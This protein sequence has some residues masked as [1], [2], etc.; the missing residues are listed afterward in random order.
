MKLKM[1]LNLTAFAFFVLVTTFPSQADPQKMYG[2]QGD[3]LS[4]ATTVPAPNTYSVKGKIY[5]TKD[6]DEAKNYSKEG[7]ASYYHLKFNGNKTASGD[8]YNSSLFTAAHKTLP[9]NSYALVTNLHNN[10]KVI[11]RINDRG[12]FSDKRLIDLSHAAA[13]ELGL[14]A[15]GTGQV[16][17][18]ALHVAKNGQLSGAATKTLAMHAKTKEAAERLGLN[19]NILVSQIAAKNISEKDSYRLKMLELTSRSQADKLI[20]QLSLENVKTEVNRAGGKYEIHIGPFD[21]KEQLTQ[22]R[23]QLQKM[24]SNKPLIVYTYKN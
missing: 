2:I 16:R 1:L 24:V 11:V 19:K 5:T 10:R 20:T 12:P 23:S 6:A 9:I 18:E 17:I 22:V 13:K 15:R 7:L 21:N 4:I 8:I 14:I 3:K